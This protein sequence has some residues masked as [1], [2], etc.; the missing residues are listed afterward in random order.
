MYHHTVVM[1]SKMSYTTR[2][3]QENGVGKEK[4]T[5][6]VCSQPTEEQLGAYFKIDLQRWEDIQ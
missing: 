4:S 3:F 2:I 6:K 5:K 1:A